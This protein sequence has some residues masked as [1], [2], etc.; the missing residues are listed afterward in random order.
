MSA[1][2]APEARRAGRRP[3]D[4][5]DTRRAILDAARRAFAANGFDRATIRAIAAAA[6][7]DPASV[8]HHFG[9]KRGLF[10]AAHELPDDP[11]ALFAQIAAVPLDERG[12]A[13]ALT[14]LRLFAGE[15]S[16]GLSL[17][18]AA[19]SD[20]HAAATLREFIEHAILTVG[21]KIL[22]RPEQD[23]ELR[24][25]LLAT[26]LMGIAVARQVLGVRPLATCDLETL[27][28]AV[29]PAVQHYIDPPG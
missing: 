18:R 20:E 13:A 28:R 25:T 12:H 24:L 6:G 14:Y 27:A 22:A 23:G 4:P 29:A 2:R 17:L 5:E 26:H 7:V 21:V 11:V 8:M 19:A 16:A 15:S 10:V 3:G 1:G 9:N